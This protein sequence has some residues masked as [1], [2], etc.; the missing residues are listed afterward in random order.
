MGA[1]NGAEVCELIDILCCH[2]LANAL[3]R[4]I[5]GC[6]VVTDLLF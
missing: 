2:Y 6:I 4:I 1:Y 5:L 3:V